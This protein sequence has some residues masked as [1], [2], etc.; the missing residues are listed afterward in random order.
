M[1][2][3][4]KNV[5]NLSFDSV[6]PFEEMPSQ[7]TKEGRMSSDGLNAFD[8]FQAYTSSIIH[9]NIIYGR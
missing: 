3:S 1:A 8:L 4:V 7:R 2:V 5:S 6:A 9:K